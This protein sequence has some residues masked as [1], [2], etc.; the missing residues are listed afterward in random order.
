MNKTLVKTNKNKSFNDWAYLAIAQYTDKFSQHEAGVL[1]DKDPEELHQMRV[2]MRKLR[3][4]M[5]G[6][7]LALNLPKSIQQKQIGKIARILGKLRDLDVLLEII[8]QKY[9]PELP[10]NEID[11]LNQ[12]L[13]NIKKTRK[14]TFNLVTNT[15]KSKKYKNIK[16]NLQLWLKNP[17]FLTDDV[18]KIEDK[19]D[20]LLSTSIANFL[21]HTGWLV[22][23]PVEKYPRNN[24]QNLSI[25]MVEDVLATQGLLLHD[26]RKEAK[27]CRYQMELFKQFYGS[28][29]Q[30]YLTQIKNLQTVLGDLQDDAVLDEIL[31][32]T[33]GKDYPEKMPVLNQ[34][35]QIDHYQQWQ[36][37]EDLR[38]FFLQDANLDILL[39][40]NA[41]ELLK[42]T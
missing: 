35:I 23:I 16:K 1:E 20:E 15:L 33:L 19:L 6:F 2:G 22:S 29:Y 21:S 40:V 37:W 8:N 17:Q 32:N 14:K 18:I 30:D 28:E 12:V 25:T 5:I 27:R 39:S 3:S 7:S 41:R 4:A 24:S 42:Q 13:K 26:L 9:L 10:K 31:T 34:K 36:K 38:S 11:S